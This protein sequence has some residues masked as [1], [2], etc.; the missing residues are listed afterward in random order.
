MFDG[1]AEIFAVQRVA[2]NRWVL[3]VPDDDPCTPAVRCVAVFEEPAYSGAENRRG[4]A[5]IRSFR[6]WQSHVPERVEVGNI[7]WPREELLQVAHLLDHL[8]L[9]DIERFCLQRS[10]LSHE[11][12]RLARWVPRP[13]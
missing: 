6:S 11:L 13:S 9:P 5:V 12:R 2:P 8:D 1:V 7:P 10:A 4:A 3:W